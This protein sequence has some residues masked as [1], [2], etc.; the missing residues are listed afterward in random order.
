MVLN[1]YGGRSGDRTGY[2]IGALNL[3]RD[4]KH[5]G[6]N[7]VW[8]NSWDVIAS[9]GKGLAQP[10]DSGGPALCNNEA[11]G[12][13]VATFGDSVETRQQCGLVQDIGTILTFIRD[14]YLPA[15]LSLYKV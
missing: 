2:I 11:V 15:T 10:G 13:L 4:L 7:R 3:A 14:K 9:L 8:Q 1:I 5:Y 6:S 12:H